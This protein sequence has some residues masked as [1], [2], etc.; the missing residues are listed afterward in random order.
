MQLLLRGGST[1]PKLYTLNPKPE[2]PKLERSKLY[3]LSS[4]SRKAC[5]Q[6]LAQLAFEVWGLGLK[7]RAEGFRI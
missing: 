7:V 4:H 1:Q 2:A 6:K 5:R 3:G